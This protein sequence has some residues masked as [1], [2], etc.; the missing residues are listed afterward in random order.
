MYAK[1]AEDEK[2]WCTGLD[3]DGVLQNKH[4]IQKILGAV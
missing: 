4:W 2:A 3:P 1:K